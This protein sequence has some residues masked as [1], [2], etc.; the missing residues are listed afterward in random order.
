MVFVGLIM[1]AAI[2][3]LKAEERQRFQ[4]IKMGVTLG[5]VSLHGICYKCLLLRY[6]SYALEIHSGY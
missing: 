4:R 2:S 3:Q 1:L 6:A 5:N